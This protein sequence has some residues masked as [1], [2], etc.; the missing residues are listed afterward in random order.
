MGKAEIPAKARPLVKARPTSKKRPADSASASCGWVTPEGKPIAESVKAPSPGEFTKPE[1]HRLEKLQ[2]SKLRDA[3]KALDIRE[4]KIREYRSGARSE[5]AQSIAGS[6]ASSAPSS[7]ATSL[8]PKRGRRVAKGS[9]GKVPQKDSTALED[10]TS[11]EDLNTQR[12][13][14]AGFMFCGDGHWVAPTRL[15]WCR[16]CSALDDWKIMESDYTDVLLPAEAD[17]HAAALKNNPSYPQLRYGHKGGIRVCVRSAW[18]LVTGPVKS[19]RPLRLP[20][21][22]RAEAALRIIS[23][24]CKRSGTPSRSSRATSTC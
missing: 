21:A 7:A 5:P 10:I 15:G 22:T 20:R 1:R 18:Q 6:E 12:L 16:A 19:K 14:D 4:A 8:G 9:Y 3:L 13:I 23:R 17:R 2:V 24:G 11:A